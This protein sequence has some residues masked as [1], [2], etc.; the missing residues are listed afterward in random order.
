LPPVRPRREKKQETSR[1][2]ILPGKPKEMTG[3][4]P[5][6]VLIWSCPSSEKTE[7]PLTCHK[8]RRWEKRSC[9]EA[10]LTNL[11]YIEAAE[12]KKHKSC[13]NPWRGKAF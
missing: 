8:T 12:E 1:A 10:M 6:G 4:T 2:H 5:Q 3:E 7:P 11:G 9:C 13:A